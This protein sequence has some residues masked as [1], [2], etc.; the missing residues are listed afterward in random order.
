VAVDRSR[1]AFESLG[2][3]PWMMSSTASGILG[4]RLNAKAVQPV[5]RMESAE[6]ETTGVTAMTRRRSQT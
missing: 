3:A 1:E 5:R 6:E 2:L 4:Q